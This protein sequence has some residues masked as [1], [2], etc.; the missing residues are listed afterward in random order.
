MKKKPPRIENQRRKICLR[1][2]NEL[3]DG[4]IR[5][6]LH[7][8]FV[9][10]AIFA[11][12]LQFTKICRLWIF[13]I[14]VSF[15]CEKF[16]HIHN[17]IKTSTPFQIIVVSKFLTFTKI[18]TQK[19]SW[20]FRLIDKCVIRNARRKK[21]ELCLWVRRWLSQRQRKTHPKR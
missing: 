7:S 1:E 10:V 8:I 4:L 14:I 9:I 3:S 11:A 18:H 20:P 17:E 12:P 2:F 15:L 16:Y 19:K 13:V 6:F 21:S 5:S